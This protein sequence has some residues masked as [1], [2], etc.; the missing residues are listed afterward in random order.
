MTDLVLDDLRTLAMVNYGHFTSMPVHGGRVRGLAHHLERLD[1]DAR[2]LFGRGVPADLVRDRIRAAVA[3]VDGPCYAKVN[4]FARDFDP[5]V[6]EHEPAVLVTVR[7]LPS[8]PAPARMCT[9]EYER[10][11]PHVKHVGTFGLLHQY[12]AAHRRGYDDVVFVDRHGEIS[13][14]SI[15]NVCFV[16]EDTLV[17]PSAPALPGIA[18]RL[19][20]AALAARGV[21][22]V[23]R[24]VRPGELGSFRAAFAT[25]ALAPVQVI[26][27]VD[28]VRFAGADDVRRVLA[29]TYEEI[30]EEAV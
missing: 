12:R 6:A 23:T 28:D 5:S 20:R 8:A 14:A 9:V 11:L 7:S 21:P 10:D 4:V 17:W 26:E 27:Q 30:P 18:M 15:A 24:P 16:Q 13:E 1:R 2:E 29:R 3:G 19:L 25:N 22:M